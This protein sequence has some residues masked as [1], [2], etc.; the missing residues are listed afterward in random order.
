[1]TYEAR[2]NHDQIARNLRPEEDPA[3]GWSPAIEIDK[4]H[5]RFEG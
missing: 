3:V 4:R 1:M 5:D 2:M